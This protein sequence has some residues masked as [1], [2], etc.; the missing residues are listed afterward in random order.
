[1]KRWMITWVV[2]LGVATRG[3]AQ[4]FDVQQLVLDIQKLS[5]EK[6]LLTDLYSGYQILEKG[7][8]AIRDISKGSFDLHREFLDGLLAVSPV[9]KQYKRIADIVDMQ[10]RMVSE[11]KQAWGRIWSEGRFNPGEVEAI[12]NWYSGMLGGAAQ[13]LNSL[14]MVLTDGR[15]RANDG[16]R[17][18]QID[19]LYSGMRGRWMALQAFNG[20]VGWLSAQRGFASTENSGLRKLFGINE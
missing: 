14:T 8:V 19:E 15:I 1:M 11:Y 6:Q 5:Q 16:E 20:Q 18:N 3:V 4:G 9:V 10:V 13:A 2:V 12:G 17:I 7:Y